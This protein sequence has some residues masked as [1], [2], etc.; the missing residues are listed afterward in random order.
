MA[1][2]FGGTWIGE[3]DPH[4]IGDSFSPA[5][6]LALSSYAKDG[7][8]EIEFPYPNIRIFRVSRNG[9]VI[10]VVTSVKGKDFCINGPT[11][12]LNQC[13][14]SGDAATAFEFMKN[15]NRR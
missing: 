1:A 8:F 13:L 3:A 15:A 4:W 6:K 10:H 2:A 11:L 14:Y 7:G 9:K 5:E 12:V